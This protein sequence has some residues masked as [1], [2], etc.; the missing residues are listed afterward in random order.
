MSIPEAES[1]GDATAELTIPAPTN[2]INLAKYTI[3]IPYLIHKNDFT[4]IQNPV[5]LH[6]IGNI[7]EPA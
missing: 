2:R 4:P 7:F 5:S 1:A 3:L 6:Q